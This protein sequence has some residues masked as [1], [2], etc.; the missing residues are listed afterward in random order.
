MPAACERRHRYSSSAGTPMERVRITWFFP[1][2]YGIA[3]H[4]ADTAASA[5]QHADDFVR[6]AQDALGVERTGDG[7]R[8]GQHEFATVGVKD[9]PQHGAVTDVRARY[10]RCAEGLTL[11]KPPRSWPN[12]RRQRRRPRQ[13][14]PHDYAALALQ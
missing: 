10:T 9:R 1:F 4:C 5:R 2:R 12:S 11:K 6:R 7:H 8:I 13:D 3:C 14:S